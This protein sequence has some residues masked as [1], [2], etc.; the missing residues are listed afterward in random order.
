[1]VTAHSASWAESYSNFPQFGHPGCCGWGGGGRICVGGD[2][3]AAGFGAAK[4]VLPS[5]K[6]S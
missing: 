4:V 5:R 3:S 2:G 6:K 1:M